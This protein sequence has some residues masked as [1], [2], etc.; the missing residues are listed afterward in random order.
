VASVLVPAASDAA[1]PPLDPP[2]EYA[3]FHGF[4]VTPHSFLLRVNCA[5][6]PL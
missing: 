5:I 3:V 2:G 4:R 6:N 1:E